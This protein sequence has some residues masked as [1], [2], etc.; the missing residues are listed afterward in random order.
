MKHHIMLLHRPNPSDNQEEAR[1]A[2]HVCHHVVLRSLLL[3]K[4]QAS[5]LH[6]RTQVRKVG[7]PCDHALVKSNRYR[8]RWNRFPK[9]FAHHRSATILSHI[10]KNSGL[11]QYNFVLTASY[12][13]YVVGLEHQNDECA[14]VRSSKNKS[15]E[16]LVSSKPSEFSWGVR[17]WFLL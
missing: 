6:P 11:K 15:A 16:L 3:V 17:T 14:H 1:V 2:R 13:V 7:H 5:F 10:Y 9:R 4:T 12:D 8:P